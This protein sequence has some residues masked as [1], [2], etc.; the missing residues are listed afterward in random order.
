L[1]SCVA[2]TKTLGPAHFAI[3]AT[4]PLPLGSNSKRWGLH[5]N[6]QIKNWE[7]VSPS[8]NRQGAGYGYTDWPP[9]TRRDASRVPACER[10]R[11]DWHE[12]S[13]SPARISS[14]RLPAESAPAL[15]RVYRL[16]YVC[17]PRAVHGATLPPLWCLP[18]APPYVCPRAR[19]HRDGG[20]PTAEAGRF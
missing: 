12:A 17:G 18:G 3:T 5:L 14:P 16:A 11:G 4:P 15:Q 13:L 9:A 2:S 10:D 7:L 1:L 8:H 20:S 19:R 6:N